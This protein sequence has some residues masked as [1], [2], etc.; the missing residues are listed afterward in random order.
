MSINLKYF[1]KPKGLQLKILVSTSLIKQS[2]DSSSITIDDIRSIK[3]FDNTVLEGFNVVKLA[4]INVLKK[5][6]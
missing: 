6:G 3:R 5:K 2:N 4:R 1:T